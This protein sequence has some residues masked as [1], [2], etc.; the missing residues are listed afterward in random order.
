[1]A[2]VS[3]KIYEYLNTLYGESS[4]K[5]Y[6]EFINEE[7]SQYIRSNS[8]KTT[9]KKL[10]STLSN[11]YEIK[12]EQIKNIENAL[13]IID[14]KKLLGKTIEHIIGE[15][16]IQ[17]LSSMIPPLILSPKQDEIVLDLCAAPGSK[18]T[19]LGEM[20]NNSGTLVANEIQ[21]DRLKMLVYNIDRM[22]LVNTGVI[23]TKGEWLSK[24]YVNHFDKILVDAPCSGLGI[25]QKKNEVNDWWS[26]ER[27]ERLGDLQLRLL[28]A[29]IKMAKIG[30]EIVYSTCTLTVEENEL[31]LDKVLEKYPVEVMQIELPV[32]SHA[33]F[34]KYDGRKLNPNIS[35]GKRIL[36][37][38]ADTDGFF[39]IKLI[40]TG[41]T[42]PPEQIIPNKRELKF[43]TYKN[44]ELNLIV[45]NIVTE[46]QLPEGVLS[47]YQYLVK[48]TDIFLVS[49]EWE[50]LYPGHFQ[51]IGT[52]LGIID[53]N[54]QLVLHTQAAQVFQKYISK[55]IYN[56]E[57]KD[58]LKK[59]LEG[60]IIKNEVDINGQCVVKYKEY[61]LGT[62][63]VT[64][65]GI[66]SRFPR[67]KRTQEI[68][69]D[70]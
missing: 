53:K 46:F 25:I 44:K 16:Y 3:N 13:K 38:E 54:K 49:K 59:Y 24:N 35:K 7:P 34:T 66:K 9:S 42:Y 11:E 17:G 36:P 4:A 14:G 28:I 2:Q 33:A 15:Y 56:I 32:K 67:A 57:N 70:F 27:V 5:K 68:Y 10:S 48:G 39:I 47:E 8:L 1:M 62:A 64:K 41:E 51:R 22:N 6:I 55:N 23:H 60:G 21:L 30:G 40:K 19:G 50:D 63:V 29:G 65:V 43:F 69:T 58:E 26:T 61:M 20:M 37:W 12:T 52:K 45:K 31:I 18:T